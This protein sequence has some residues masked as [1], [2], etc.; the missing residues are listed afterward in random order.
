MERPTILVTGAG[1]GLG[2]AAVEALAARGASVVATARRPESV[3]MLADRM[4][5]L[6]TPVA[7]D[8]LDVLD[9]GSATEVIDRHRPDVLVSNAGTAALGPVLDVDDDDAGDQFAIHAVAPVRLARLAVPHMRER[10]HGRIV[11]VSSALASTPLPGT[12]WYGA[13]KAALASLTDTLRVELAGDGIDVVLVDL[14]AVDTPIW[15][16]AA[17]ATDGRWRALTSFARPLFTDV[18]TAAEV[19]ADAA[20]DRHPRW[21]YRSGLGATALAL[22]EVLPRPVRDPVARAVFALG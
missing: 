5:A 18:V 19:V 10:G 6:G 20:C 1:S 8:L 4:R 3:A 11:N 2:L 12:G 14:G 15:D 13:A 7:T 9:P 16:D 17:E 22:A 21:R